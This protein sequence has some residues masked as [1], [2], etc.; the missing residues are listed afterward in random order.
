M[1]HHFTFS[2]VLFKLLGTSLASANSIDGIDP[3]M[4]QTLSVRDDPINSTE[5]C[6]E[7]HDYVTRVVPG[8]KLSP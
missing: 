6:A 2:L 8:T 4:P 5:T 3:Q 1:A 7:L